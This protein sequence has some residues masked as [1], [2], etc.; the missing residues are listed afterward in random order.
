MSGGPFHVLRGSMTRRGRLGAEGVG[1]D[2]A[3]GMCWTQAV[4]NG[5]RV[6]ASLDLT[7]KLILTALVKE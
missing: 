4:R 5:P 7:R 6:V 2:G 3:V 1:A